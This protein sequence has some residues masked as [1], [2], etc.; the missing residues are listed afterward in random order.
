MSASSARDLDVQALPLGHFPLV[1]ALLDDL[2]VTEA[3][4]E[5]LP[6]DPRS[7]VSDADCVAVMVLNILGGRTALYRMESWTRKLPVDVLVGPH[8]SPEDFTDARLARALDHLHEAGTDTLLSA[9]A[10]RYL[11]R[12][13]RPR[14]YSVHQ[15]STSVS[16]YGAYEGELPAWAPQML[17]GYSKDHRP[18][19]KQLVFGLTLHG[20]TGLPLVAWST[21][22]IHTHRR[23]LQLPTASRCRR[24]RSGQ[25]PAPRG[26]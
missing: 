26:A 2:G 5:R 10:A 7:H 9:I 12:P 11:Q 23:Q 18:D 1:M 22:T 6:R 15:D 19:L 21:T 4:D 20:P 24:W 8:A 17:H 16:A 25:A 13:D 14:T 3:L